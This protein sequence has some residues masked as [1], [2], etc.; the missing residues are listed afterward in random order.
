MHELASGEIDFALHSAKDVET[1]RPF[2][3][4]IAAVL[5][6]P[7]GTVKSRLHRARCELK[8]KLKDMAT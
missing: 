3:L 1:W 4:T 2:E 6:L 5:E 7:I 8:D